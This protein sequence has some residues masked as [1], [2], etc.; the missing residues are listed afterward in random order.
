MAANPS[1]VIVQLGANVE[2]LV[3]GMQQAISVMKGTGAEISGQL[4]GMS[5]SSQRATTEI[6]EAME[7]LHVGIH[8]LLGP[9]AELFTAYQAFEAIKGFTELGLHTNEIT[10]QAEQGIAA[11]ITTQS[12]LTDASGRALTGMEA[13]EGA[14]RISTAQIEKLK[15]E[16]FATK[17]SFEEIFKGFETAVA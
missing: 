1:R 16:S 7:G 6:R 3:T 12:V 14:T 9:L 15:V 17:A 2:Q 8:T 4:R 11:I 13:L 5:E 10:E